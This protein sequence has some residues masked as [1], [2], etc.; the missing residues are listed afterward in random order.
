MK[1]KSNPLSLTH[2]HSKNEWRFMLVL[3]V[4]GSVLGV[5]IHNSAHKSVLVS[6]QHRASAARDVTPKTLESNQS[7]HQSG[8]LSANQLAASA[9][10]K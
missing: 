6:D 1:Q 5:L 9:E 4:L 2:E 8:N 7:T 3:L 10:T